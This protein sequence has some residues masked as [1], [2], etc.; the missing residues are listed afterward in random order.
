MDN[1]DSVLPGRG[2]TATA[3]V[4]V[5]R[6]PFDSVGGILC[7]TCFPASWQ[8][9]S[10]HSFPLMRSEHELSVSWT[11]SEVSLRFCAYLRYALI[12]SLANSRESSPPSPA[13]M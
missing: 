6:R 12:R 7:R 8:K 2:N 4:E 13:W 3:T 1:M 10:Q 5:C 11:S 9:A